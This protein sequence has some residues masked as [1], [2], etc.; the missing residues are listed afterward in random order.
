M[1]DVLRLTVLCWLT[2]IALLAVR[3]LWQG[4]RATVFVLLI[5]HW[6]FCGVPLLWDLVLG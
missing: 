6:V 5:G 2:F 1:M 3:A 4:N